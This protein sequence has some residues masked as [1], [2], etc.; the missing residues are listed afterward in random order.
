MHDVADS[1]NLLPFS[2]E[3]DSDPYTYSKSLLCWWSFEVDLLYTKPFVL[4]AID[5]KSII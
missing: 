2:I 3:S 4:T 5:Y 1:Q